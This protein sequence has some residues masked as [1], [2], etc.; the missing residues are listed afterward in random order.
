MSNTIYL[1]YEKSDE[2]GAKFITGEKNIFD[3]K[4]TAERLYKTGFKNIS[5]R[6][7]NS[8]IPIHKMMYKVIYNIGNKKRMTTFLGYSDNIYSLY[9]HIDMTMKELGVENYDIYPMEYNKFIDTIGMIKKNNNEPLLHNISR[10]EYKDEG[11][12]NLFSPKL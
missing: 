6:P 1:F 9:C 3:A 7:I 5:L 11:L 2:V 12:S 8:D 4:K 10:K